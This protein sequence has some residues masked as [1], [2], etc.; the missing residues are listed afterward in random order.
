MGA[1]MMTTCVLKTRIPRLSRKKGAVMVEYVF[2]IIFIVLIA[3]IGIKMF[4]NTVNNKLGQNN[5]SVT[6]AWQ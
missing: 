5:N 1:G 2:L 6:T 4:G 3:L